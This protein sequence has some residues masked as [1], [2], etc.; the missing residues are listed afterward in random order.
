M[1]KLEEPKGMKE[2]YKDSSDSQQKSNTSLRA[3]NDFELEAT[4]I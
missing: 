4:T 3:T 2:F 1:P